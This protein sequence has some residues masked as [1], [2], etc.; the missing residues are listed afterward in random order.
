M[1][2]R[3][4]VCNVE[5]WAEKISTLLKAIRVITKNILWLKYQKQAITIVSDRE[6]ALMLLLTALRRSWYT[7]FGPFCDVVDFTNGEKKSWSGI[8]LE[9]QSWIL[10]QIRNWNCKSILKNFWKFWNGPLWRNNQASPSYSMM[11]L[12]GR[13][14]KP[15]LVPRNYPRYLQTTLHKIESY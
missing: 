6:S 1:W 9:H 15:K 4:Q 3:T 2:N 14:A 8:L 12:I 13:V 5:T 10:F 7:K 11:Q